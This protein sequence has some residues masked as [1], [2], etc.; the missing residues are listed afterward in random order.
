[1]AWCVCVSLQ[2]WMSMSVLASE[3]INFSRDN[4]KGFGERVSSVESELFGKVVWLLNEIYFFKDI[5]S[6]LSMILQ[7]LHT[8]LMILIAVN[9]IFKIF[10]AHWKFRMASSQVAATCYLFTRCKWSSLRSNVLP[11]SVAVVIGS[12]ITH[13]QT[14]T[15]TDRQTR[16]DRATHS[17]QQVS[18]ATLLPH[19][20][21]LRCARLNSICCIV[22]TSLAILLRICLA[23]CCCMQAT[24]AATQKQQCNNEL[25]SH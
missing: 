17:A 9:K 22:G 10:V 3:H 25:W 5:F 15:G 8:C 18:I 12:R 7:Q 2:I 23:Y 4:G 11:T 14:Q 6:N 16:A 20:Y 1:M 19:P 21:A 13:R 24:V